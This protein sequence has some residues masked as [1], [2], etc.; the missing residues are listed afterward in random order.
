MLADKNIPAVISCMSSLVDR[1]YLGSLDTP[2]AASAQQLKD[3]LDGQDSHMF[4]DVNSAFQAALS[5]SKPE[6]RIVVFGSFYTVA[7][8][9]SQAV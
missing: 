1:W 9:L 8:L 7:K 6:D 3:E 4:D 5:E 2:R